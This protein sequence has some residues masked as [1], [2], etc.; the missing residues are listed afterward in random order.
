MLQGYYSAASGMSAALQ[1]Q[2]ILA[3]NLA[4]GTVPGYRRQSLSFA[5]FTSPT[6]ATS[7]TTINQSLYGAEVAQSSTSYAA[8]PYQQTGNPLDCAI[9]G[10]GFFVLDGPNGPLY[11]RNGQ[12][13]INP[14]GQLVTSSGYVVTGSNGQLNIPTNAAQIDI[15]QDGTVSADN[16]T[17]G[18][19]RMAWFKDQSQLQRVGTTLFSAP[20]GITPQISSFGTT[21]LPAA[22][23]VTP[24]MSSTWVRQGY[25]EGSNVQVVN[26]MVQMIAGMRQYEAAAKAMR[27]LSDAM[28]QRTS[29]QM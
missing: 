2:D 7:D 10:D 12:F 27:S 19:L 8:G 20:D 3:Q 4:H 13:Q 15:A 22:D 5:E 6:G 25:R 23:G 14:A 17:V 11:T 24:Q 28:Q 16:V 9:Q 26:E 18:Q 1:N 29:A 21:P